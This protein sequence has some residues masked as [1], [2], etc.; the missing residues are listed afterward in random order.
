MQRREGEA[1]QTP[2]DDDH[3]AG[4]G[5]CLGLGLGLELLNDGR[6][7]GPVDL[8]GRGVRILHLQRFEAG[9]LPV[10]RPQLFPKRSRDSSTRLPTGFTL[11]AEQNQLKER[12]RGF[13][14]LARDGR[15]LGE[16][17]HQNR[18]VETLVVLLPLQGGLAEQ[19][20]QLLMAK[21][22]V[23]IRRQAHILQCPS[24]ILGALLIPS[25]SAVAT[26]A[27]DRDTVVWLRGPGA[28][29]QVECALLTFSHRPAGRPAAGGPPG[30]PHRGRRR[31]APPPGPTGDGRRRRR[32]RAGR[33]RR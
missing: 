29:H 4:D 8:P 33:C 6:D 19:L 3:Q 9:Q 23:G 13:L 15:L 2:I 21:G 17:D 7:Q 30:A 14:L 31:R 11:A 25:T 27:G 1:L 26:R 10:E 22:S 28:L 20:L 12:I 5:L 32:R 16:G 18:R 24:H